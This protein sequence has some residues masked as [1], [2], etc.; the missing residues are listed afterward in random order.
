[1]GTADVAVCCGCSVSRASLKT[2]ERVFFNRGR[3]DPDPR[4]LW[5]FWKNDC[6]GKKCMSCC[7]RHDGCV[8]NHENDIS[9]DSMHKSIYKENEAHPELP[10]IQCPCNEC[11]P[12]PLC[13]C[14]T[15]PLQSRL[16]AMRSF[17]PKQWIRFHGG[18]RCKG[19]C[20][21]CC[22]YGRRGNICGNM[23]D[24]EP[25][26]EEINYVYDLFKKHGCGQ[27]TL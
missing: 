25:P 9:V 13:M 10:P 17:S 21:K 27:F 15:E 1:M 7:R 18:D 24:N 23:H 4:K 16:V 12:I 2:A 19:N 22:A 5:I 6:F 26:S 20:W 14:C 11:I 8:A 3:G